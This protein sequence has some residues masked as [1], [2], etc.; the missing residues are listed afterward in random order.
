[1]YTVSTVYSPLHG[2]I[3][4]SH[5]SSCLSLAYLSTHCFRA[6]RSG[7]PWTPT[8][9]G[10][11]ITKSR[12]LTSRVITSY[13]SPLHLTMKI[14]TTIILLMTTSNLAVLAAECDAHHNLVPFCGLVI[15]SGTLPT[16]VYLLAALRKTHVL[17]VG[18]ANTDDGYSNNE[19]SLVCNGGALTVHQNC[20]SKGCC[21][22]K[23]DC[24]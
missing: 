22:D 14:L 9:R 13:Y 8:W 10:S 20:G 5:P 15:P 16:Q 24:C 18:I 4:R 21:W 3:H 17:P 23:G 2:L 12:S 6:H 11:D 19:I 1:M 7:I